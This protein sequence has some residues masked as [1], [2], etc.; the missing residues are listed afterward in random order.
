[1]AHFARRAGFIALCTTPLYHLGVAWR[2][3]ARPR[4]DADVLAGVGALR[5]CRSNGPLTLRHKAR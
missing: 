2:V 5:H 4:A 1:M 3:R